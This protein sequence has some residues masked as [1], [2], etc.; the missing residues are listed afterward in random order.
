[1]DVA[2]EYEF[3]QPK[4]GRKGE[5]VE[6]DAGT[7]ILS[8]GEHRGNGKTESDQCQQDHFEHLPAADPVRK[9]EQMHEKQQ[10]HGSHCEP[11]RILVPQ[12]YC[13]VHLHAKPNA[14][15]GEQRKK[16]RRRQR[17]QQR[18]YAQAPQVAGS[19]LDDVDELFHFF[20]WGF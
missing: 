12:Q 1:M 11:N 4:Q 15:P 10:H 16:T 14:R 7:G 3:D 9:V 5:H 17:Q 8:R 18:L 20:R 13:A 2:I 19:R 6:R